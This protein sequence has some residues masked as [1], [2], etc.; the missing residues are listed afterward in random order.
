MKLT[1]T[2]TL[3]ISGH[4]ER[5]PIEFDISAQSISVWRTPPADLRDLFI[6]GADI[7]GKSISVTDI[8][9]YSPTGVFSCKRLPSAFLSAYR[10]HGLSIDDGE[11]SKILAI[12]EGSVHAMKLGL[13]LRTSKLTLRVRPFEERVELQHESIFT[14]HSR[15]IN[16][17]FS[18]ALG[19]RTF[20]IRYSPK[21]IFASGKLRA[22]E[23]DILGH[24]CSLIALNIEKLVVRLAPPKVT[25]NYSWERSKAYD[26]PVVL[27][28]DL[29]SS[30][31]RIIDYL[32]KC[33]EETRRKRFYEIMHLAE[34]FRQKIFLEHRLTNL[35][36]AFES[37]DGT[38][39]ISPNRVEQLLGIEKG[40]ARFFCG[41]RNCLVHRGMSL[42]EAAETTHAELRNQ[43][44]RMKR[45]AHLPRTR[46]LAWRLY[47]TFSRLIVSAYFRQIGVPKMNVLLSKYRAF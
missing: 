30:L 27:A 19:R 22:S 18:V 2:C 38:R 14:N 35:L 33:Q 9:V 25:L 45:F 21:Y 42:A 28:K 4:S 8:E 43:N 40:D 47:V 5:V 15:Y 29:P 23:S 17:R 39:T 7:W 1:G 26:E 11:F 31:Q 10:P 24:A 32:L 36:K 6:A 3:T 16:E 41:V 34:G 46:K 12:E 37:F 13:T 44:V 20:Q